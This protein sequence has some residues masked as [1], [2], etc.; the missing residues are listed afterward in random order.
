M[1]SR[2]GSRSW[3]GLVG[4]AQDP[5]TRAIRPTIGWEVRDTS[6][7]DVIHRLREEGRDLGAPLSKEALFTELRRL[8]LLHSD[9]LPRQLCT[10][11]WAI[12]GLSLHVRD[13]R[14]AYRI[15][16]LEEAARISANTYPW[17]LFCE[18]EDGSFL[19]TRR[20]RLQTVEVAHITREVLAG[21]AELYEVAPSL[22]ES[23]RRALDSGGAWWWQP[24]TPPPSAPA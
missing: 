12:N 5:A 18:L 2:G 16:P 4:I 3:G 13:G 17:L 11:Y 23:L 24:P 14:A 21:R 1:V 6:C 10:L 15:L 7:N 20:D 22:L 9:E 8:H 19:A